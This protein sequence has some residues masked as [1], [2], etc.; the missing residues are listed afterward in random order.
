MVRPTDLHKVFMQTLL[1][2]R[3]MRE[4]AAL[5]LYKRA[6]NVITSTSFPR[7]R[8]ESLALPV[9]FSRLE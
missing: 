9:P 8:C 2:R 4:E 3:F 7:P 6:V 5:E 1:T